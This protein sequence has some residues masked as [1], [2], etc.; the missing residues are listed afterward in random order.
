V[1]AF[2]PV[3]RRPLS[4]VD[5]IENPVTHIGIRSLVSSGESGLLI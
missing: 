2:E 3:V 5:S 4:D 1:I